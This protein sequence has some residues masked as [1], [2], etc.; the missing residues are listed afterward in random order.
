MKGEMMMSFLNKSFICNPLTKHKKTSLQRCPENEKVNSRFE[1]FLCS[2]RMSTFLFSS[3]EG[4]MTVEAAAAI[5]VFLFA[6]LNLLSIILMFGEYS[7]NLADMHQRAKMLSVH[8]HVRE[9]GQD[10]N[11]DLIIQTKVIK[12]EPVI[13][14]MGFKTK[15]AIVNCRMRKWTGFDV[16]G[17]NT[18]EVGEE[19]V[20]ITPYGE[21]YHRSR[22]CRYL[23]LKV[24]AATTDEIIGYRNKSGEKYYPCGSCGDTGR[25]GICFYT[26]Y[27]NRY[28][29]MPNC[30]ALKRTVRTVRISEVGSRHACSYCGGNEA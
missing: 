1:K 19:W 16:M 17:I 4:S 30:S 22:D 11:N 9:A 26:E 2:K 8:A 13:P 5:P 12:L 7:T 3:H 14:I 10:V 28:H 23:S 18:E 6:I 25:S 21:S 27:G 20:Y 29:I 24:K 15:R